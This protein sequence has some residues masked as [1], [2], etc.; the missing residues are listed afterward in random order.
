MRIV[1]HN[2]NISGINIKPGESL[3]AWQDYAKVKRF[4]PLH[5]LIGRYQNTLSR[6]AQNRKVEPASKFQILFFKWLR[7][8]SPSGPPLFVEFSN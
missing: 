6:L 5:K 8:L 2:I 1:P 3:A 7:V 4:F